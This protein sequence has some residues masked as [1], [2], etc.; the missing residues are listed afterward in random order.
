MSHELRL[1]VVNDF[2][3]KDVKNGG[4]GAPLVPIGDEYLFSE[5]DICLNLGG[6]SNVSYRKGGQRV[7]FDVCPANMP[8]NEVAKVTG[9]DFDE[10]GAMARS[11]DIQEGLLNQLNRLDYYSKVGPKSL[12]REW[13]ISEF[14]K[15]MDKKRIP[16]ID[17]LATLVEH[18]AM[19]IARVFNSLQIKTALVTGGGAYNTFLIERIMHHSTADLTLPDN[20]LINYKEAMIFGFLGVLR[21]R[22]EV[23]VLSSVTGSPKDHCAGIIHKP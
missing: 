13:Y 18:I 7:A 21:V 3:K 1:P 10:D 19:Q 4:Q 20:Q 12:G 6:F 14:K 15:R 5:Y 9:K 22:N 2:R 16:P 17:L 11:G 23:N 8:L